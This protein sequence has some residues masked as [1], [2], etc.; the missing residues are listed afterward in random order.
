MHIWERKMARKRPR[1]W[2]LG[3][4]EMNLASPSRCAILY[5]T[6]PYLAHSW[7]GLFAIYHRVLF[8]QGWAVWK[9]PLGHCNGLADL[10]SENSLLPKVVTQ[11]SL[12]FNAGKIAMLNKLSIYLPRLSLCT[13]TSSKQHHLST[14][15]PTSFLK[16][17]TLS[18]LLSTMS[19]AISKAEGQA[20]RGLLLASKCI[21][22]FLANETP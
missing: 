6:L 14:L 18:L 17:N 2:R 11:N 7:N 9:L 19:H 21:M 16:I 22:L 4:K 12:N 1:S 13:L 5:R 10:G 8:Q 15:T 3:A 20:G